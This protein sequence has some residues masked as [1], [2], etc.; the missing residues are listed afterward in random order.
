MACPVATADSY[1]VTSGSTLT[2]TD[3]GVVFNDTDLDG[4]TIT[5]VLVT[6]PGNGTLTLQP[7]GGLV[8]TP[9]T[10]F[11]GIDS[12]YYQVTDGS[13]ASNTVEVQ[14]AV[15]SEYRRAVG[16]SAQT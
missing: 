14:I 12:F 7:G 13:L 5:T 6:P 3:P 1:S 8:Y 9:N 2:E 11:V 16:R 4:D 15:S 10:G